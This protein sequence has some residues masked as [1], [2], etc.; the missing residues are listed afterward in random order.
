[1][2]TVYMGLGYLGL[3]QVPEPSRA[4]PPQMC[5]SCLGSQGETRPSGLSQEPQEAGGRMAGECTD[6]RPP[7]FLGLPVSQ[8]WRK[9][10]LPVGVEPSQEGGARGANIQPTVAS[11]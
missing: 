10:P 3:P 5:W 2:V 7:P 6:P 9:S 1:M 11:V 4:G 8:A